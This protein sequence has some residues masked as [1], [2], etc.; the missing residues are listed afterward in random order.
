M[1][2]EGS[3][4]RASWKQT[5]FVIA[6]VV[7]FYAYLSRPTELALDVEVDGAYAYLAIQRE[8]LRI[9]DISDQRQPDH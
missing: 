7:I 6:L 2:E 4:F 8:G 3:V 9:V 5:Y 1:Q